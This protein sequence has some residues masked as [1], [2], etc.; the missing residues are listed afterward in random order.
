M[1][2]LKKRSLKK[3]IIN[4]AIILIFLNKKIIFSAYAGKKI[5]TTKSNE[6]KLIKKEIINTAYSLKKAIKN[7]KIETNK[8][9][10][11]E[12]LSISAEEKYKLDNNYIQGNIINTINIIPKKNKIST[13]QFIEKNYNFIENFFINHNI[14]NDNLN[15]YIALLILNNKIKSGENIY[16]ALNETLI[17]IKKYNINFTSILS[18]L[19]NT[20]NKNIN[21]IFYDDQIIHMIQQILIYNGS[22]HIE[23]ERAINRFY[24]IANREPVILI[25]EQH[26]KEQFEIKENNNTYGELT[27]DKSIYQKLVYNKNKLENEQM[28]DHFKLLRRNMPEQNPI[29][30]EYYLVDPKIDSNIVQYITLENDKTK[31][32]EAIIN[33]LNK[34]Y[35]YS[36]YIIKTKDLK[37]F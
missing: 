14:Q 30:T 17:H 16:Q 34:D 12:K 13:I 22:N 20:K 8:N 25:I 37:N 33:N 3:L 29:K 31:N 1:N 21:N 6:K 18:Y 27:P 24:N 9:I 35:F 11:L 4:I 28:R 36:L 10:N 32:I 5:K 23:I 2:I 7:Y 26:N 15:F 19:Y